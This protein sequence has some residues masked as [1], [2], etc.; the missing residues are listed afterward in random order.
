M[1]QFTCHWVDLFCDFLHIDP[2]IAFAVHK[3][4]QYNSIGSIHVSIWERRDFNIWCLIFSALK[5]YVCGDEDNSFSIKYVYVQII[6]HE[7]TAILVFYLKKIMMRNFFFFFLC[8][9]AIIKVILGG[10]VWKKRFKFL[11]CCNKNTYLKI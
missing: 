9:M 8:H 1:I 7:R 10:L 3:S 2:K 6:V 11:R 4:A 5:G